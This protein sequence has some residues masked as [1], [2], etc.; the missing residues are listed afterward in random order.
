MSDDWQPFFDDL[1]SEAANTKQSSL[2]GAK[3]LIMGSDGMIFLV[4]VLS[5]FLS[6]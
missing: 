1:I 6:F 3:G 5:L 4:L 2:G